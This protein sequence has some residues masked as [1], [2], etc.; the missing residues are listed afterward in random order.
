MPSYREMWA[1]VWA[2]HAAGDL[3]AAVTAACELETAL[4][5]WSGESDATIPVL[6]ARAW[7]AL[8]RRADWH[9]TRELFIAT[10]LR[11]RAAQHRPEADTV[12]TARNVHAVWHLLGE[13]GP[14]AAADLAGPPG[15][16]ARYPRRGRP[17]GRCPRTGTGRRG[18]RGV[19]LPSR[20]RL[21][22]HEK[23]DLRSDG[24]GRRI[25]R[26][27]RA[28]QRESQG[29]PGWPVRVRQGPAGRGGGSA[30]ARPRYRCTRPQ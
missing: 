15:G 27:S 5:G 12:R 25:R 13:E 2:H 30:H 6:I 9:G 29:R 3:P 1:A 23:D 7:L 10:A 19:T 14:E 17:P 8:C 20:T 28:R 11:C 22:R 26:R 24:G 4:S 18:L 21:N 16:H